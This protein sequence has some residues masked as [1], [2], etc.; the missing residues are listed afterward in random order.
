MSRELPYPVTN[1]A[2]V[3][4]RIRRAVP[5]VGQKIGRAFGANQVTCGHRPRRA[6]RDGAFIFNYGRS[7]YPIWYDRSKHTFINTPEAVAN[8]VDKRKTLGL[9]TRYDV[10]CLEYT[11]DRLEAQ[12]MLLQGTD[13]YARTKVSSKKG[14][15]IV[16]LDS[17]TDDAVDAPL[18]TRSFPT[19]HEYRVHVFNGQVIDITQKKR[20]GKK[21]REARGIEVNE[22]IRNHGRGWVFAHRNLHCDEEGYRGAISEISIAACHVLG[23]DYGGVD[24]LVDADNNA[25]VC[26]V[27]SAPG[28]RCTETFQAYLNAIERMIV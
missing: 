25:V 19:V 15:G 16:L 3:V 17:S 20:M 6:V 14:N 7:E 2:M 11:T 1:D 4:L 5:G 24:L 18:Y 27:N 9:L 28:M 22:R 21:K 10:P 8:C 13:V 12:T 26:E 23:L